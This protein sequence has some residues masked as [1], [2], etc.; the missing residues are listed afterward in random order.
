MNRLI[1]SFMT[2]VL[3]SCAASKTGQLIP[4]PQGPQGPAGSNGHSLVSQ[5]VTI[6]SGLLC[7]NGGESLDIYLDLDDSLSVS[8]ADV[9]QSSLVACNGLN[10]L[11]GANGLEGAQGPQGI[12]GAT[13]PQGLIGDPGVAGPQGVPGP[14]GLPGPI[15]PQGPQ[16]IPGVQGAQGPAGP[17][18]SGATITSYT[19]SSCTNI[20]GTTYYVKV[21]SNVSIY[22]AS[23]CPG[24]AKVAEL[25]C[26]ES[27]WFDTNKLGVAISSGGVRVINFN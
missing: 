24:G 14:Q 1:V 18:G 12:P 17:S 9:Y 4:G 15:G 7:P 6:G 11:N 2:L 25:S 10:G 21:G 22:N 27:Y 13:G 26:G 5:T 8:A 19:S 3:A 16:G 23:G 20:L